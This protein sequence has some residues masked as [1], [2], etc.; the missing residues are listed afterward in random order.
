M[1][2]L[3][4]HYYRVRWLSFEKRDASTHDLIWP[5]CNTGKIW[6][7]GQGNYRA[8]DPRD[9]CTFI[10][11]FKAKSEFEAIRMLRQ[12]DPNFIDDVDFDQWMF[13][14][15]A[16]DDFPNGVYTPKSDRFL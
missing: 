4:Y 10:A 3:P 14:H 13:I 9:T 15:E 7:S 11:Y 16:D 1:S 5:S 12:A 6:L 8:N 2:S